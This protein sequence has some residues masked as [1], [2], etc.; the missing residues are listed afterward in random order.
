M[1]NDRTNPDISVWHLFGAVMRR[2]RESEPNLGLHRVAGELY[3]G[4]STLA[5]WERGER[6]PPPGIVPRID[7]VYRARGILTALSDIAR[8]TD[9]AMESTAWVPCP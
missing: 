5:R 4:F 1:A 6:T 8:R 9:A 7:Q 3:V 2:L